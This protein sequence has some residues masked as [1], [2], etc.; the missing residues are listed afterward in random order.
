MRQLVK[1]AMVMAV[2]G[3]TAAL[4]APPQPTKAT[5][6][7]ASPMDRA[8]KA[9]EALSRGENL[10]ALARADEA[11]RADPKSAWAH[12][13]RAAA[14]AG[15]K[16]VEEAVAAYD[17]AATHFAA[18][19]VRGKSLSLWGK[20]HLLYRVGR[21]TEAGSA[22]G[23]YTKVVGSTDPQGTALASERSNSCHPAPG[24][25]NAV[26]PV[27]A[28]PAAPATDKPDDAVVPRETKSALPS[29]A[30]P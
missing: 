26:A 3:S 10:E 25:D 1:W 23:E 19:D 30:K 14:L 22:F 27:A 11:L 28:K 20:A 17:Q 15:L 16:R 12:Y 24:A 29:L 9:A 7:P 13:N 6:I 21:C 8:S 4:A 2:S 5:M 18:A